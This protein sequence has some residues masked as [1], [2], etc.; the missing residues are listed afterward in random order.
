MISNNADIS[1]LREARRVESSTTSRSTRA[2]LSGSRESGRELC[3]QI[4]RARWSSG[5]SV[6]VWTCV[7]RELL[8]VR[9]PWLYVRLSIRRSSVCLPTKMSIRMSSELSGSCHISRIQTVR[10][11]EGGRYI[12]QEPVIEE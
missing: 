9:S 11:S 5:D 7:M 6:R 3:A 8:A 12:R 1:G 4:L 2:L 10:R